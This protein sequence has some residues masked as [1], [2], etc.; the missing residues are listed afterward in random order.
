MLRPALLPLSSPL[1]PQAQR[2]HCRPPLCRTL[3]YTT[4]KHARSCLPIP[5]GEWPPNRLSASAS[6]LT[7]TVR[8]RS[9]D[10]H[11][12]ASAS[13][14]GTFCARRRR[15][16]RYLGAALAAAGDRRQQPPPRVV[17]AGE[18][19]TNPAHHA[20][21]RE[22]AKALDAL[23]DA[24]TLIGLEMCYRQQ[25]PALDEFIFGRDGSLATLARSARDR[26]GG[27][28]PRVSR[29]G[30]A[31]ASLSRRFARDRT[32]RAS[33]PRLAPTRRS[34]QIAGQTEEKSIMITGSIGKITKK[35]MM[36]TKKKKNGKKKNMPKRFGKGGLMIL[37]FNSF[38]YFICRQKVKE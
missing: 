13:P 3:F 28:R 2:L 22:R 16:P 21:Q 6:L 9:D 36:K 33:S 23:D 15:A 32:R 25:Q 38:I 34:L 30:R 20:A 29:A 5:R 27:R 1:L 12:S 10:A 31:A 19:H 26:R 24:P 11:L 18:D 8:A 7:D 17:F 35:K 14:S 4:P 37:L